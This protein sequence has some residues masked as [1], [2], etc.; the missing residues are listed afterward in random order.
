M[1]AEK[2]IQHAIVSMSFLY[3]VGNIR[4]TVAVDCRAL[5]ISGVIVAVLFVVALWGVIR[6]T[7]WALLLVALLAAFDIV[8][9]SLPRGLL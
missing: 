2:V 9:N 8:G 1:S 3:N 6:R 4:S 5:M 7:R